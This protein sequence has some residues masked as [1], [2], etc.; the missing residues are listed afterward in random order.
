MTVSQTV[1]RRLSRIGLD[2]N[3]SSMAL[4]QE[5]REASERV[6]RVARCPRVLAQRGY[7]LTPQRGTSGAATPGKAASRRAAARE[8]PAR[9]AEAGPAEAPFHYVVPLSHVVQNSGLFSCCTI[10]FGCSVGFTRTA[11]SGSLPASE[12]AEAPFRHGEVHSQ[13]IPDSCLQVTW[14]GVL[15][16]YKCTGVALAHR[17]GFLIFRKQP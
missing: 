6:R 9:C 12:F 11:P 16:C 3:F 13:A 8:G 7:V 15:S 2:S 14:R 5:H 17:H 1:F 4:I 10:R